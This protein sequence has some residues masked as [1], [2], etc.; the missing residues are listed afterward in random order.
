LARGAGVF[1]ETY[2]PVSESPNPGE[3]GT[4]YKKELFVWATQIDEPFMVE[5][6]ER[7]GV[8]R[9]ARGDWLLQY[10]PGEYG[11]VGREIFETTYAIV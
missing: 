5:L 3:D 1:S 9:G 4:Y 2:A 11:I 7:K 6:S 10:A 8:L